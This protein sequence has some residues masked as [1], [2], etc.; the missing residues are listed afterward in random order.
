MTL[1]IFNDQIIYTTLMIGLNLTSI[2]YYLRLIN[3]GFIS[4]KIICKQANTIRY[5]KQ[6]RFINLITLM[7]QYFCVKLNS[8]YML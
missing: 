3:V 2:L 4:E 6:Y 7:L 1:K 8:F 5:A